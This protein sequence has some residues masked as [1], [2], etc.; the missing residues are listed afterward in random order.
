MSSGG[1]T[2]YFLGIEVPYEARL[3]LRAMP[4]LESLDPLL[5]AIFAYMEGSDV[6]SSRKLQ[7]SMSLDSTTLSA[8]FTGVHWFVRTVRAAA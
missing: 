1:R 4:T 3:S 6:D 2:I 5:K 8:L 7:K